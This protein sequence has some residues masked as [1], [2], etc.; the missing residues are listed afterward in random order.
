MSRIGIMGGTFNPPHNGHVHAAQQAAQMLQFD[1]LLLIPDNVPPH[2]MLPHGSANSEQRL[3]MT[4]RMAAEIPGA[5]VCDMELKRGGRSYTADTLRMLHKIYPG[6]EFFLIIGTDMLLT[7]DQWREPETLCALA[8]FAV[9]ARDADDRN[10]IAQKAAW[11]KKTWDARIA[12]VDCP[13]LPISSTQVR[14]DR[15]LCREMVPPAV[16]EYITQQGLYF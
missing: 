16:Y 10:A 8:S 1:R 3:E 4:R 14:A 12:I 9:V 2:K 7:L 6:A 15:A 5:E 13:A 11:L